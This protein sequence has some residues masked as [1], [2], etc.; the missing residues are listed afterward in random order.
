MTN[1]KKAT[2]KPESLLDYLLAQKSHSV[3]SQFF[4]G[5]KTD[6]QPSE[7]HLEKVIPDRVLW[8]SKSLYVIEL[9]IQVDSRVCAQLEVQRGA[10]IDHYVRQGPFP[11]KYQSKYEAALENVNIY[12][13]TIY[14]PNRH[15][16]DL[17]Q[18]RK[19]RVFSLEEGVNS[20]TTLDYTSDPLP[21]VL[22]DLRGKIRQNET[23]TDTYPLLENM[24]SRDY[25]TE[26]KLFLS[27]YPILLKFPDPTKKMKHYLAQLNE[28]IQMS[29]SEIKEI[30]KEKIY[31]LSPEERLK[32]LPP[33]ERLK[34]LPPEERLKGLT[35]EEKKRL[36]KILQEEQNP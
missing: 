5:K 26:E 6:F 19:F 3:L 8:D 11:A 20:K 4:L 12:L 32:G 30:V 10:C 35:E 22:A 14:Q 16:L 31:L 25:L 24:L 2:W 17:L 7:I 27:R 34:G 15:F 23:R 13:F 21:L 18:R 29:E 9:K 1:E 33:E 36:L 28:V